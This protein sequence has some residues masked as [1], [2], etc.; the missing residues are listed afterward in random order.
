MFEA[1]GARRHAPDDVCASSDG[2]RG[3]SAARL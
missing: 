2:C 3:T 1:T